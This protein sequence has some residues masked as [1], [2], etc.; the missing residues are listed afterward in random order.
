MADERESGARSNWGRSAAEEEW[1]YALD[2]P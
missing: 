1:N 2:I